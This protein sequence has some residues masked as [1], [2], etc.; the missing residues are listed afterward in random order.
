[1][2]KSIHQT[3]EVFV[4]HSS[5]LLVYVIETHQQELRVIL[6]LLLTLLVLR[7]ALH[8]ILEFG[9]NG[10]GYTTYTLPHATLI[11]LQIRIA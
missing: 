10:V 2:R 8:H 1:M 3:A 5:D 4:R 11:F 6:E 7:L 9:E